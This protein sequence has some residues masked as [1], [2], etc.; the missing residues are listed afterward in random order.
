MKYLALAILFLGTVPA[1]ADKYHRW[2]PEPTV[3]TTQYVTEVTEVTNV[4]EQVN[5]TDEV[6]TY[7]NYTADECQGV[8]I[9]MAGANNQMYYSTSK[10][11]VSLGVGECHGEVAGSLM[12]GVKLGKNLPLLNGSIAVDED[13]SAF[14]IGGTWVFK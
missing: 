2:Y 6:N 10:P 5:V 12:F 7:N 13:V 1:Q 11:Q 3:I 8:A 14:G 9:A 4:T